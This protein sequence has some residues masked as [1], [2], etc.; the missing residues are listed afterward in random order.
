MSSMGWQIVPP[1][2]ILERSM[3][4]DFLSNTYLVG[5]EAGAGLPRRRRRPG[6]AAAR[7]RPTGT[8]STSPTCCS[9]TTTT[10]TWRELGE[11][12]ERLPDAQVLIH[13]DERELLADDVA[14]R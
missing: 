9:P 4:D 8:G 3:N 10:T 1:A 13:P 7:G 11:V 6:R 2:V 5:D 14:G 12:L